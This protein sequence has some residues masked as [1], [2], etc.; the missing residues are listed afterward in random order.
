MPQAWFSHFY[1]L[2]AACNAFCLWRFLSW[3][4]AQPALSPKQVYAL[5]QGPVL[6]DC[7]SR[8][9]ACSAAEPYGSRD[10]SDSQTSLLLPV[11]GCAVITSFSSKHDNLSLA[12]HRSMIMHS[13]HIVTASSKNQA[14]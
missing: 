9:T 13:A 12:L 3:L 5:E 2:G 6:A 7:F 8:R 11:P 1:A 10:A 4:A 14:D